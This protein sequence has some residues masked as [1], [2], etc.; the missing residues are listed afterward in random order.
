MAAV[1]A[2]CR[3]ELDAAPLRAASAAV[4]IPFSSELEAGMIADE[5]LLERRVRQSLGLLAMDEAR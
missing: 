5:R 2:R 3:D 1:T 4:P